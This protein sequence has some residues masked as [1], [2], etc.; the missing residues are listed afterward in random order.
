LASCAE[1]RVSLSAGSWSMLW[2]GG[3]AD[4]WGR[5]GI[6]T[7]WMVGVGV[8]VAGGSVGVGGWGMADG[9]WGGGGRGGSCGRVRSMGVGRVFVAVVRHVQLSWVVWLW[10]WVGVCVCT[11]Q[12]LCRVLRRCCRSVVI[13]GCVTVWRVEQ[14]VMTRCS[15]GV[16]A[17]GRCVRIQV[18]RARWYP[19]TNIPQSKL[20]C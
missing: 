18:R 10:K 11:V 16:R 3:V 14:S 4:G 13:L 9:R 20:F 17:E 1:S 19:R 7:E 8:G 5:G 12:C 2:W 6:S 15:S